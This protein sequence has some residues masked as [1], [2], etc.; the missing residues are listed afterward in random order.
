MDL[1]THIQP[2]ALASLRITL[3]LLVAPPFNHRGVPARVKAMLGVWLALLLAPGA[4]AVG[5]TLDI[6]A[7][8]TA[9]V[10]EGLVGAGMGFVVRI[11]V[12]AITVAGRFLDLTG[13][14][15]MASSFDPQTMIQGGPF[16]RFYSLVA[17]VLLFVSDAYQLM[18]QGL[19]RSFDALPLGVGLDLGV[20]A[21]ELTD[22][23]ADLFLGGLM[24]AGPLMAV[25]FLVDIGFGLLS[26]A[27]P[28]LNA[29]ALGFPLK[30]FT[31]LMLGATILMA[32]PHALQW[33]TDNA[34]NGMTGVLP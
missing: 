18:I 28:A 17:V 12:D 25:L 14:F 9:L 3:F 21:T 22:R 15:E 2:V 4:A 31:T 27:A 8:M 16:G 24:I 7:F 26:R 5:E 29:F 32:L 13:G 33:I 20:L 30:V 6:P 11:V 23:F 1:V 19:A 34:M 10:T